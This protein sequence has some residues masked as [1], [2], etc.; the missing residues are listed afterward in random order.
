M[1]KIKVGFLGFGTFAQRRCDILLQNCSFDCEVVGYHDPEEK[2]TNLLRFQ[3]REELIDLC[4]A[5]FVAVPPKFSPIFTL[6][7]LK[8][9]KAVFCEKP[10]ARCYQDILPLVGYVRQNPN[11]KLA[12]GFNH[13]RHRS[14]LEIKKLTDSNHFGNLLWMR[15]R[16]GKEVDEDYSRSWRSNKDLNG[17]GILIDQG[18][19]MVDFMSWI[20]GGFDI[21][22]SVLSASYFNIKEVEDNAFVTMANSQ[23]GVAASLHSTITQWRYLFSF[24]LFYERGS[25]VLNGLR[26]GSGVYGNEELTIT[27]SPFY[28]EDLDTQ[29]VTYS[30]NHS[31]KDEVVTFINSLKNQVAYP[32]SDIYDAI[33]TTLLMDKIYKEAIWV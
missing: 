8:K 23:S 11:A 30:S 19:H 7:V 31:W 18:I 20:A 32:Y 3:N 33:D 6:D 24:E 22:S 9:G 1:S 4:D 17:G 13:R 16:Y 25:I 5:I 27:P 12:Y 29:V 28:E 2:K 21:T 26:T 15:G 14:I 10:A